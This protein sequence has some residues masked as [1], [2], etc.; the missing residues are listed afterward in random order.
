M[1]PRAATSA[2]TKQ[3]TGWVRLL[4]GVVAIACFVLFLMQGHTPPGATGDVFRNNMRHGIDATPLFYT[5]V[6]SLMPDE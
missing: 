5:D 3:R 1:S 6:E 2:D 4:A